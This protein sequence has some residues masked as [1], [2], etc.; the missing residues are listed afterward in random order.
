MYKNSTQLAARVQEI[1]E[2]LEAAGMPSYTQMWATNAE[3][4]VELER[5]RDGLGQANAALSKTRGDLLQAEMI[6]ATASSVGQIQRQLVRL[7][8]DRDAL[9]RRHNARFARRWGADDDD[10]VG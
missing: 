9:E 3:L 10:A 8:A 2:A 1:D 6:A 5:L 4:R 7:K